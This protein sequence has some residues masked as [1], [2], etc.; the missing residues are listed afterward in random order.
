MCTV[1]QNNAYLII[2]R[3]FQSALPYICQTLFITVSTATLSH[4]CI[5]NE[6]LQKH[7]LCVILRLAFE[8]NKNI[9]NENNEISTELRLSSSL[10]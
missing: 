9:D 8:W 6:S 10:N 7:A 4:F 5:S 2:R 1:P 3:I